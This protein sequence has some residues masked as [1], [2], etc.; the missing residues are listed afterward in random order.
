MK[1]KDTLAQGRLVHPPPSHPPHLDVDSRYPLHL[2]KW[3]H[4]VRDHSWS[5][6]SERAATLE[7]PKEISSKD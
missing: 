1:C 5:Q 2:L 4:P 7:E 6:I 3:V